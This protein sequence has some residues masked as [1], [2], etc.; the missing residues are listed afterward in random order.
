MALGRPGQEVLS[1][2]RGG[3]DGVVRQVDAGVVDVVAGILRQR[4]V[5][6]ARGQRVLERQRPALTV[7]RRV[8]HVD[9]VVVA[10]EE[11][12]WRR[13]ADVTITTRIRG[14]TPEEMGRAFMR[15]VH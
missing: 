2:I 11:S 8:P 9:L 4:W 6:E 15:G 10:A 13:A 12:A 1:A 5:A 3:E 14:S 7:I